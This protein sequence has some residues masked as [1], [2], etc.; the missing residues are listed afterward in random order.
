MLP[1]ASVDEE[2]NPHQD[3]KFQ[4]RRCLRSC[5]TNQHSLDS[6]DL[7]ASAWDL[8]ILPE[9]FQSRLLSFLIDKHR[10]REKEIWPLKTRVDM[11]VIGLKPGQYH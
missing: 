10:G 6:G 11:Y 1:E 4:Y 5:K 8:C 3:I 2:H 9:P 7:S